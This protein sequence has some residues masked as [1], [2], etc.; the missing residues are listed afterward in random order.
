[1]HIKE[2]VVLICHLS[3]YWHSEFKDPCSNVTVKKMLFAKHTCFTSIMLLEVHPYITQN[4]SL[5][6]FQM[7]VVKA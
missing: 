3:I 5:L 4:G 1:M 2:S 6:D 7:A